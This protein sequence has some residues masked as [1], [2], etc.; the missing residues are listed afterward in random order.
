MLENLLK[1]KDQTIAKQTK[2]NTLEKFAKGIT[3][4]NKDMQT[5]GPQPSKEALYGR[6]YKT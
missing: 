5:M 4:F 3:K 2:P 6:P 1:A